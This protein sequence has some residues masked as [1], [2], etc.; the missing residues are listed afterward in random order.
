MKYLKIMLF[1]SAIGLFA[2]SCQTGKKEV[3]EE[4]FRYLADEFADLRVIRYRIPGWESLT[5]NQKEYIYHL[6]EAAKSGRDIFW[7]QN[8]KHGIKIRKV[9]ET[10]FENYAGEKESND[11]AEFLVYAKRVF[12]SNGI[13]HHYA[14]DKFIPGCSQ[15]Y[16]KSLMTAS[17][18]EE[19]I[20]QIIPMLYDPA[21]YPQRKNISGKGD[22]LLGSSVNFYDGVSRKEAEAFYAKMEDPKDPRPI[23]YG[24]NSKLVKRDGKIFEEVYKVG[25]LYGPAIEKI[26]Y[27]LEKAA[28]VAENDTQRNYI[29]LLIEYYKTG[30]LRTWDLYNV[31]WV[32]DTQSQVDFINGFIETYN[33][34]LGM[35][36]TWEAVV[37]FKDLEA[38]KRTEI[39]SENAQWFEDNSPV[40]PQYKK[41]E[42]KG[43]SAKVITVA[44]L[45][46]D[47]HPASP[48]GINLPNADWIRKEHGSK[49]VT[50]AN[51]S[52]AYNMA[53]EEAPK[54]M[55]TEFSWDE[56]EISLLKDYGAQTGNLHTD[57][58]ECLGH[59]SGQLRPGT[60][61]NA[62]KEFSSPLEEARADIFALYYLAD[63]KLVELGV[64]P[65]EEAYKASY[66]SYIRNGLF[67]QFVRVDLGKTVT[68][69]HMQGR[70]L[71]AEWCF[72]NGKADNVIEKRVRDGKTYFVV[73]DFG[74]LRNLFAT[75][76]KEL[77]RIKSEGDYEAGKKL[78][79]TYAVNIDPELHKELKERYAALDLKPYGG[80]INPEITP[81]EKDGKVIDYKV[82]YPADFL[83]QMLDYGK[84][85]STLQ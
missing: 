76:L 22:L 42:V 13:H 53:A 25:G 80:F 81:V 4:K 50:I 43:V 79:A 39:I 28:A 78:I 77:Q 38:S 30:D 75:L 41:K 73:N 11:Y 2:S 29:A 23:S 64:L 5:F 33:D 83:Q 46:G 6:S 10:I 70:K 69:A 66:I 48:L 35:K 65:N 51:I 57:L 68:Q 60:S 18:Q 1:A 54:S 82:E 85:Y 45:G 49:S 71:I 31:A 55:T 9:L 8:F 34:P 15:E 47:C 16:F 61:S 14:E 7:D 62:L 3:Q 17:G 52:D 59:G 74:K 19:M 63:S 26:I 84:K 44:Q 40:D 72:E 56:N 20:D 12:F 58:H 37:N 32:E 21:L 67:T 27:H 36:A 24:L